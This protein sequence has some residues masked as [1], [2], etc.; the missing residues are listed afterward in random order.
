MAMEN[1]PFIGDFPIKTSISRGIPFATFVYQKVRLNFIIQF[2]FSRRSQPNP[3]FRLPIQM[4]AS[5]HVTLLFTLQYSNMAMEHPLFMDDFPI[6]AS[7]YMGFPIG[8][9]T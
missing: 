6:E 5:T 7:V 4:V 3:S 2:D 1:G 9:L 8:K